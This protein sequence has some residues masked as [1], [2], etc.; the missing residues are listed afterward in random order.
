MSR[1][2]VHSYLR[3]IKCLASW[4]T[5][6]GHLTANPFLGV[7]PYYKK[8]GVMPVLEADDRIPKVARP[9]DLKLLLAGCEGDDPRTCATPHSSGC[10]IRRGSGLPTPAT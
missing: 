2:T 4:L 3:S 9:S 7:N 5:A 10:S 1:H 6:L 8:S